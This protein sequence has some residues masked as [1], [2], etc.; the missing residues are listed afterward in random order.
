MKG[1]PSSARGS[2]KGALGRASGVLRLH[3]VEDVDVLNCHACWL[4]PNPGKTTSLLS[5]T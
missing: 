5:S 3:L 1:S 4:D 2:S